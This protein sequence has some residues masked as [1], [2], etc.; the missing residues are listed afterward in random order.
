MVLTELGGPFFCLPD[1]RH[2]HEGTVS[3]FAGFIRYKKFR[4]YG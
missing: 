4:K 3:T 1:V 2:Y